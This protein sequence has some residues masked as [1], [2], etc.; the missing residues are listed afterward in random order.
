M[1]HEQGAP[2]KP[3]N[4]RLRPYRDDDLDQTVALWYRVWHTT[5][6]ALRHP[7]SFEEWKARFEHELVARDSIW[8]A[9][10]DGA[11]V[12]FI[13]VEQSQGSLDQ[14]FV[15][16]AFQGTGLGAAL[17]AKAK[18]LSPSGLS[19]HTLAQN[20]HARRF[21]ERHGFRAE[22]SSTNP[23]NGMPSVTYRWSPE[24]ANPSG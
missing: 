12:A 19:L 17:L 2:A 7:Q 22:E 9:E 3:T 5:F 18:E 21:Y 11:I 24:D 8:V 10:S 20:A 6:P 23:V 16:P 4:A 13:A 1:G 15:E 14:I